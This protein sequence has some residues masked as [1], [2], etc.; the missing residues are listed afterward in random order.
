MKLKKN[1]IKL[2]HFLFL[3]NIKIYKYIDTLS[4]LPDGKSFA[5]IAE[6]KNG[7]Y[8]LV[9]DWIESGEYDEI[10]NFKCSPDWK[11]Y[12]FEA[13]KNWEQIIVKDWIESR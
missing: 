5:F 1:I 10:R 6:K 3:K 2:I 9:K 11:S 7:K 12:T 4:I 8:V 13:K